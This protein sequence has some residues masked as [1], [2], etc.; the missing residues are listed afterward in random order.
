MDEQAEVNKPAPISVDEASQI[1]E[2]VC[3]AVASGTSGSP[4]WLAESV[5]AAFRRI[6]AASGKPAVPTVRVADD[7]CSAVGE[8]IKDR[9]EDLK[10][11]PGA[12]WANARKPG[13]QFRMVTALMCIGPDGRAHVDVWHGPNKDCNFL[14]AKLEDLRRKTLPV[15]LAEAEEFLGLVQLPILGEPGA[16]SSEVN[17]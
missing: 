6:N 4:D 1:R 17:R 13:E 9:Y 16:Q 14:P 12:L 11:G 3:A 7:F 8:L 15:L 5:I 10:R 2:A